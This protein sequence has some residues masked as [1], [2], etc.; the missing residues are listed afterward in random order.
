MNFVKCGWGLG[1]RGAESATDWYASQIRSIWQIGL[2]VLLSSLTTALYA[3]TASPSSNSEGAQS[4]ST[5]DC[6][7]PLQANTPECSG[8][9]QQETSPL[10]ASQT[11]AQLH[12]QY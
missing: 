6:S 8:Q 12:G 10:P 1:L 7:D 11:R 3:Q 5:W 4:P 9:T 2:L